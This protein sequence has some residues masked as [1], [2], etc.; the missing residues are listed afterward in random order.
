IPDGVGLFGLSHLGGF[1]CRG[2]RIA[3]RDRVSLRSVEDRRSVSGLGLGLRL[4]ILCFGFG[5][6]ILGVGKQLAGIG[7][8]V[9][10]GLFLPFQL[11]Q[12]A[13]DRGRIARRRR[14]GFLGVLGRSRS[15]VGL[16]GGRPGARRGS[17]DGVGL[18]LQQRRM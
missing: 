5:L 7:E 12:R 18:R 8:L 9:V 17:G 13:C 14:S 6:V 11:L 4:Q 2:G 10:G 16:A 1:L 15:V 3:F